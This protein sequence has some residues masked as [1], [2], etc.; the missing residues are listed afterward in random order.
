MLY[1]VSLGYNELRMITIHHVPLFGDLTLNNSRGSFFEFD[2][3]DKI[4]ALTFPLN[5]LKPG[6]AYMSVN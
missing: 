1:M 3:Y 6:D 4:E 5:S 2:H